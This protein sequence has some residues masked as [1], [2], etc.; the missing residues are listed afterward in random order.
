MSRTLSGRSVSSLA[1]PVGT[2]SSLPA[3]LYASSHSPIRLAGRTTPILLERGLSLCALSVLH[4]VVGGE[5]MTTPGGT[6]TPPI[7]LQLTPC[8]AHRHLSWGRSSYRTPSRGSDSSDR[9]VPMPLALSPPNTR[10]RIIPDDVCIPSPAV[11][12][13]SG[14]PQALFTRRRGRGILRSSGNEG[15]KRAGSN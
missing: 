6:R 9:P 15:I 11:P 4:R 10:W 7:A 13:L 5:T 3:S 1:C 2:S 14:R 12:V 8:S